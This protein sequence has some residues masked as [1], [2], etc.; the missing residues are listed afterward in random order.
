VEEVEAVAVERQV[1][2]SSTPWPATGAAPRAPSWS[3]A[4]GGTLPRLVPLMARRVRV[5]I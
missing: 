4:L 1:W 2:G 3:C 5:L